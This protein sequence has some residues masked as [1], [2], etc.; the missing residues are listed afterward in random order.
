[1]QNTTLLSSRRTDPKYLIHTKS[2]FSGPLLISLN[3]GKIRNLVL[4]VLSLRL[5]FVT[6]KRLH[7]RWKIRDDNV[8]RK[9]QIRDNDCPTPL[10]N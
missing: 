6:E 8:F 4:T 5:I 3:L 9:I 1:M 2:R 10:K 7:G